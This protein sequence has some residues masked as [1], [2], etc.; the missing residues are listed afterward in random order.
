MARN[1]RSR[2]SRCKFCGV[3]AR[4]FEIRGAHVQPFAIAKHKYGK[5]KDNKYG[6][7]INT[8]PMK[9]WHFKWLKEDDIMYCPVFKASSSWSLK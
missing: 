1:Y 6:T 4:S 8:Y 9:E 2:S 7:Y 5:E 3:Y